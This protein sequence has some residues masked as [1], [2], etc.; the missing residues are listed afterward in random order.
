[1]ETDGGKMLKSIEQ[2]RE[3]I[4]LALREAC[5]R[6]DLEKRIRAL[7]ANLLIIN[8]SVGSDYR[9]VTVER[10]NGTPIPEG[11]VMI[12]ENPRLDCQYP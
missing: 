4:R 9:F 2:Y 3:K 11:P 8:C 12:M 6:A 7:R 5:S 1:M 10:Q